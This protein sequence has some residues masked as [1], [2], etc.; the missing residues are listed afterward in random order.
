MSSDLLMHTSEH[1]HTHTHTHV[2]NVI[3]SSVRNYKGEW[4]G[5]G[6]H[7]EAGMDEGSGQCSVCRRWHWCGSL[8]FPLN[9]SVQVSTT[10]VLSPV[11]KDS[12][13]PGGKGLL[14]VIGVCSRN[15]NLW[16]LLLK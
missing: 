15:S 7:R 16:P 9:Y 13:I 12:P 2:N 10:P 1:A 11:L 6:F 3:D 14:G 8:F 5:S 4:N